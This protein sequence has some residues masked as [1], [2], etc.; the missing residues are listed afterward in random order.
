MQAGWKKWKEEKLKG[1]PP[2]PD[3]DQVLRPNRPVRS[4]ARRV[5]DGVFEGE[6]GEETTSLGTLAADDF[7][8]VLVVVGAC[9]HG[10]GCL[11][12]FFF[13]CIVWHIIA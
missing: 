2:G 5:T 10:V 6:S 1:F 12:C 4:P 3:R 11:N 7:P 13:V 9:C 8:G